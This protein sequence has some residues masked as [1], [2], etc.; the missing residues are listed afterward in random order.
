MWGVLLFALFYRKGNCGTGNQV[1][2]L[3]Q[4]ASTELEATEPTGC[5]GQYQWVP[6]P[7]NP[8]SRVG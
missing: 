5:G 4:V 8:R 3:G 2:A 6:V 1:T 7:P